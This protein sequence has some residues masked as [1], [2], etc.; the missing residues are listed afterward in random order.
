M[1]LRLK[2]ISVNPASPAQRL[3]TTLRSFEYRLRVYYNSR[4][5]SWYVDLA[6][7]DG[8]ELVSGVRLVGSFSLLEQYKAR[9]GMPQDVVLFVA[10]ESGQGRDFD[11]ESVQLYAA[12]LLQ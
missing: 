2:R 5:E 11:G 7:A 12:E 8:T 9:A 3:S 6:D 4:T 1:T 10:D